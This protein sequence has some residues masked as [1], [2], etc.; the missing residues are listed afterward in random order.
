MGRCAGFFR[1]LGIFVEFALF[2]RV[3][4]AHHGALASGFIPLA[5]SMVSPPEA[6]AATEKKKFANAA[7]RWDGLIS[8][9][10]RLVPRVEPNTQT[11]A[12]KTSSKLKAV[13]ISRGASNSGVYLMKDNTSTSTINDDAVVAMSPAGSLRIPAPYVGV[14]LMDP[15]DERDASKM[16]SAFAAHKAIYASTKLSFEDLKGKLKSIRAGFVHVPKPGSWVMRAVA[17]EGVLARLDAPADQILLTVRFDPVVRDGNDGD[18]ENDDDGPVGR[19]DG[20]G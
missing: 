3:C 5:L 17:R 13:G 11:F 8:L 12:L 10:V 19:F 15:S 6:F 16:R 9:L 14:R 18:A 2:M 1:E 20:E 4:I 7:G